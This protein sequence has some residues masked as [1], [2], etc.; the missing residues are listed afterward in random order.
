YVVGT[1]VRTTVRDFASLCFAEAG[2]ELVWEGSGPNEIG[3]EK[4]TGKVRVAIDPVYFRATEAD[5][6]CANPANAEKK[7]KWKPHMKVAELA[8]L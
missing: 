6:L 3:R 4:K 2:M 5:V 1:G 7:L 8:R